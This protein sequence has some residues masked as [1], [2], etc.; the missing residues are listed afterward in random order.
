MIMFLVLKIYG[1]GGEEAG[2]SLGS[3]AS[4]HFKAKISAVATCSPRLY[5]DKQKKECKNR[6]YH[7]KGR[8]SFHCRIR[9]LHNN[10]KTGVYFNCKS[11]CMG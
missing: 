2:R 5:S 6:E 3:I 7:I 4:F 11:F 10:N 9:T 8:I 1:G